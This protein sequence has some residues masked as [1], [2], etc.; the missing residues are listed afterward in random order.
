MT[1]DSMIAEAMGTTP[2]GLDA[3]REFGIDDA[4]P[5]LALA[6][7]GDR[8]FDITC[9]LRSAFVELAAMGVDVRENPGVRFAI[10][11]LKLLQLAIDSHGNPRPIPKAEA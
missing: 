3:M 7:V 9:E 6:R 10:D 11:R 2:A 1:V 4:E 8:L 5:D